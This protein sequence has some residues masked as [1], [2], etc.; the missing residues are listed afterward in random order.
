MNKICFVVS[1]PSKVSLNTGLVF[2]LCVFS[3]ILF[4]NT[5][6]PFPLSFR[7]V[8]FLKCGFFLCVWFFFVGIFHKFA[9][10]S[11]VVVLLTLLSL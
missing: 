10:Q 2:L 5:V 9:I 7:M 11:K 6:L 3:C 1:K 4:R 8:W